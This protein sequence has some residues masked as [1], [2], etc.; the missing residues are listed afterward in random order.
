VDAIASHKPMIAM[1]LPTT[2]GSFHR[3]GAR[4]LDISP[5]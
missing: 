4:D 1:A 2:A 5:G 3:D